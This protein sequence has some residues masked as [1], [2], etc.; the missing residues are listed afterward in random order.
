METQQTRGSWR[1][2]APAL[3][4]VVLAP[5]LAEVLPGATRTSALF[6]LPVEMG[7]WGCGA[8]LIR[9]AVRHWRL[10]WRNM[11]LLS[12]ALA[13]AEE[14][15][16][17]QS[18]LAPMV[19]Q[20]VK[21][22]PYARAFGV[23][24]VYLL[25]ALGYETVFVVFLPVALAELI[26]RDR[27]EKPWLSKA[28]LGG[29]VLYF[30]VAC[31]FAWFTW[32]QIARPKVFHV[33]AYVPPALTI[34]IGLAAIALLVL[35]AIGPARRLIARK[36]RPSMPPPPLIAGAFA[37]IAA[38]LWYG[39]VLLGFNLR[40]DFPVPVAAAGGILLGLLVLIAFPRWAAHPNWRDAHA[41]AVIA[42]ALTGSMGVGFI[43]FIGASP[44]DLYGKIVFDALALVLL[45]MLAVRLRRPAGGAG[46]SQ[47]RS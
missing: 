20:I 4:L 47:S 27:R 23:N 2:V 11:L 7:V 26:F 41:F 3:T 34:E 45:I 6:V 10:G 18:S 39:L 40:P 8:L 44:V 19:I 32:T 37:L 42:G 14:F 31:F 36:V 21:G 12:F 24:W 46:P 43:G 28:G 25:W 35:A 22:A 30:A 29:A 5:M 15:V 33:P 16:I 38:V 9:A 17:Q 1:R 13:L